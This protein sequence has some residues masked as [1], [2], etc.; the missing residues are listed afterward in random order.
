MLLTHSFARAL[1]T[2][3]VP[4]FRSSR[5]RVQS[6]LTED[7]MAMNSNSS[8][9]EKIVEMTE[10]ERYLFDLNGYIIVRGVLTPE[11]VKMANAAIDNHAHEMIER[12]DASLRNAAEGTKLYGQ[13][14]G[15]MD[16]GR[17]LEWY[18]VV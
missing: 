6:T 17:V 8:L 2:F 13:G 4:A 18:V 9:L 5:L 1:S 12:A 11:E 14:P 10:D 7:I 3:S 15:R 16:L